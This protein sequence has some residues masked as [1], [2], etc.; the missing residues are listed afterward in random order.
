VLEGKETTSDSLKTQQDLAQFWKVVAGCVSTNAN[1][2]GC[3]VDLL[4]CRVIDEPQK[5]AALMRELW[6]TTSVPFAAAD[7]SLGNFMLA[8]FLEDPSSGALSIVS[9]SI[10]AIDLYFKP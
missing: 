9:S 1:R 3:R 4:G 5:G 10:V 6:S 8:T 7:K 2:E